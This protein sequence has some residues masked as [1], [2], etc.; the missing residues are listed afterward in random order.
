MNILKILKENYSIISILVIATILRLYHINFQSLWMDEIYTMNVANPNNTLGTLLSEVNLRE[1]FPYIYFIT[2]KILFSVFGH[3]AIVARL[4][5]VI[6]GVLGVYFTYKL[7]EKLIDKKTGLYS[8]LLVALSEYCI[9]ASQDARPYTFYFFGILISYLGLIKFL[10]NSN[11]KN[12]VLYGL[13]AGLILNISLFAFISLLAQSIVI[14]F[15]AFKINKESRI[16]FIKNSVIAGVIALVMFLPNI[17]ILIKVMGIKADWIAISNDSMTLIFKEFL[18]N[19][20]MTLIFF[21]SL[22][23]YYLIN[24]F[25]TEDQIQ[26]EEIIKNKLLFSFILFFTWVSV[27]IGVI[28]FKSYTSTPLFISR[29]FISVLPVFFLIFGISLGLILNKTI[30][31]SILIMLATFM[32]LNLTIVNKYYKTPNKAQFREASSFV[33]N[34]NIK[35]EPVFTSLKYWF[36]YYLSNNNQKFDLIEK[37]SL[38]AVINEMMLDPSKIK[39]FWYVDAHGRTFTLTEA[40]QNFVNLNFYIENNYDGFDSWGKHFILLKDVPKVID[41]SKYK[42]LKQYNGDNFSFNIEVFENSNNIVKASGWAYFS[43]QDAINTEADLVFIKDGIAKRLISQKVNRPD[44]TSYFKSSFDLSNSGFSSS[45]STLDFAKGNYVLAVYLID[46]QTKK[47]GLV[48]T[49]KIVE[50]K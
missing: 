47:E 2:M 35:N 46:K 49:D 40:T 18:G 15:F 5:S 43:N 3:T 22:F 25:K 39:P 17:L 45:I 31:Y 24:L 30:R 50:I 4:F 20:E 44:V 8:A 11:I 1:G 37:P 23:I 21:S 12:A 7:G 13:S 19:S 34:N 10:K 9:Y 6:F 27:F 32:F 42:E 36:S 28:F 38:E 29:Y 41:I 48:L 14:L 33:M 16:T 26:L